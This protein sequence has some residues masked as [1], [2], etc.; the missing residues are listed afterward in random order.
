MS[1]IN[2]KRTRFTNPGH[3]RAFL[4]R[5]YAFALDAFP[6]YSC[7]FSK[8]RFTLP[9]MAACL[10]LKE[11]FELD[12]RL[13]RRLLKEDRTACGLLG[14]EEVPDCATLCRCLRRIPAGGRAA[15]KEKMT[16]FLVGAHAGMLRY[17]PSSRRLFFSGPCWSAI[18]GD[19]NKTGT[20][21]LK[22]RGKHAA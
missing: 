19:R 20:A 5:A 1:R 22:K 2:S 13:L 11:F 4:R 3:M 6:A 8:K 9:Q 18:P 15:L 17:T 12:F 21:D 14:L 16:N 7:R 10:L